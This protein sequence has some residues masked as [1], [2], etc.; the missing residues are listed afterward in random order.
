KYIHPKLPVA[1]IKQYVTK[2]ESAICKTAKNQNAVIIRRSC[3]SFYV[4]I[5]H[6][7]IGYINRLAYPTPPRNHSCIAPSVNINICTV[8]I[9][10]NINKVIKRY[11][12]YQKKYFRVVLSLKRKVNIND[13]ITL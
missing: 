8:V 11:C 5:F 1:V 12:I 10:K 7:I 4:F 3:I 2:Y 6:N 13:V 9:P